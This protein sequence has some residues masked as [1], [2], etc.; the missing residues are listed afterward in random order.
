MCKCHRLP[1]E[2]WYHQH[3][4]TLARQT[5]RS[6][7]WRLPGR[8]TDYCEGVQRLCR[9]RRKVFGAAAG[10]HDRGNIGTLMG[11][12]QRSSVRWKR[13]PIRSGIFVMGDCE[14]GLSAVHTEVAR[15]YGG[16]RDKPRDKRGCRW[17]CS[18]YAKV[19]LLGRSVVDDLRP[20]WFPSRAAS[21]HCRHFTCHIV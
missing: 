15:Q 21:Y 14:F 1:L 20:T 17:Q 5:G 8:L 18:Q 13:P 9:W 12:L 19:E 6:G 3:P 10:R 4:V 7:S 11:S 16:S 2:G